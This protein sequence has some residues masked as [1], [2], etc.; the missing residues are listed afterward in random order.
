MTDPKRGDGS[1]EQQSKE[2]KP[3]WTPEG[4]GEYRT[5][6]ERRWPNSELEKIAE[7]GLKLTEKGPCITHE[8]GTWWQKGNVEVAYIAE[9]LP[10]RERT[11]ATCEDRVFC[12]PDRGLFVVSDGM[13]GHGAGE[14]AAALFGL[15]TV[16]FFPKESEPRD[17]VHTNMQQAVV[18]S[19]NLIERYGKIKNENTPGTCAA[20][21]YIHPNGGEKSGR[22]RVSV[23]GIGDVEVYRLRPDGSLDVVYRGSRLKELQHLPQEHARSAYRANM[24]LHCVGGRKGQ[25]PEEVKAKY[26]K[27]WKKKEQE[28]VDALAEE[29]LVIQE[30]I[31]EENEVLLVPTDGLHDNMV[32]R[33][34]DD[35]WRKDM[36]YKPK[37]VESIVAMCKTVDGK[38]DINKLNKELLEETAMKNQ[39]KP[40][41]R[42]WAI[43]AP[44]IKKNT[45]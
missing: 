15:T 12:L 22:I 4:K 33:R 8:T 14:V 27:E 41:D 3:A 9:Q 20:I 18:A 45:L 24:V 37:T 28:I 19:G 7:K 5:W 31:L 11:Q 6:V 29:A 16:A 10:S 1:K 30:I 17:G 34:T 44:K 40:D 2:P 25:Q 39:R 26:G 35:D 43:I 21:I 13:G 38:L 32:V 42:G 23:G 36:P